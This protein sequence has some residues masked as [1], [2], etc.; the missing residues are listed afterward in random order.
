MAGQAARLAFTL[1]EILITLGVIGIVAAVTMPTLIQNH[2]K[3]VI[4]NQL[5]AT[6]SILSQAITSSIS[7]NGEIAGWDLNLNN[8][9]FA[10]KYVLPYLKVIETRNKNGSAWSIATLST[11]YNYHSNYLFWNNGITN[12]PIYLLANGSA[13]NVARNNGS[14]SDVVLINADINSNKKPNVLGIDG[15]AFELSAKQN[16]LIP[17]NFGYSKDLLL[18]RSGNLSSACIRDNSWQYYRGMSCASVI[19]ADGWQISND[20]PWGN[21]EKTP[22]PKE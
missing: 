2:K 16:Q 11:Q 19:I 1:A 3:K 13:I 20:Y 22:I 17:Y 14:K 5:K 7:E 21:G 10:N 8:I 9:D 12:C 4:V 18:G 6:Y 15:F